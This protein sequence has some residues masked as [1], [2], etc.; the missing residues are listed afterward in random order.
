MAERFAQVLRRHDRFPLKARSL[1]TLQVNLGKLC[2]QRCHH[3]H[4]EAGP[5][6][7]GPEDNMDRETAELVVATLRGHG[8][9][10]LDLT[11]G[12]PELNPNFRYLVREAR[13][14]GCR[15]IDRC[16]LSVLFVRGQE[17]LAG[18]LDS[19]A[20]EIIA[21]LPYYTRGRTDAQR[22]KGV[23]DQSIRGL[24][25]LNELGYGQQIPGRERVINLAYNP[26]GAYLP[27]DQKE[28]EADF[29]RRLF[30]DYGIRFDSLF[31]ITNQPIKRFLEFLEATGTTDAYWNKLEAAFNP[32]AADA[33][34][35]RDQ[36]SVGPDGRLYDCDFNQ[37]QG[38]GLSGAKR[39]L[40][41]LDAS[42]AHRAIA[43]ARHCFTCTAA[44]GSS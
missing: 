34:M 20:V 29:K 2:N 10:T 26:A 11:G 17:D 13:A 28:L 14:L 33:V 38:I 25:K 30:D 24:Q 7:S 9:G 21:S 41:D 16:N 19:H 39:H 8:F 22:G 43:T 35:C 6:R 27:G 42:L 36:I 40:R 4:V 15:V 44:A 1:E 3:C 5:E 18:F 12:A 37:M 31:V 32:L 23:F